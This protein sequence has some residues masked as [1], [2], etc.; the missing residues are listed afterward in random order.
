MSTWIEIEHVD[1][2]P[3]K[4][5]S[6]EDIDLTRLQ[7]HLEMGRALRSRDPMEYL[8]EQRGVTEVEGQLV[9]TLGGLV[10]F[11]RDP[12]RHL[13]HTAI[14]LT[15][16]SGAAPNSQQVLDIRD[17]RGT[18]FDMIDA[19]EA[20]LWAQS[21]HGFR[22][23]NGPRRIPLDQYP[24]PAL[25]E[26]VVNAMAHRDYRVTGSRVK[27]EMF[28]NQVEWSSPGGLPAGVTV[29]NI[30]KAQYTRNPI[31]VG[32]LW[33]AGYIEQRGMGLDSVVNLL[34]S[35]NLAYPQMEDTG[36]SFLIR[37]EGHG[38]VDRHSGA[39]LSEPLAQI[40]VLVESAGAAGVSAKAIAQ[41]LATPIRTVN[42]RLGELVDRGLV[43]RSGATNRTRYLAI[44]AG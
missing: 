26:L 17:L 5:A 34:G 18:L 42:Y 10:C 9:P 14:A 11:G 7:R 16:Y 19:T 8:T 6:L 36:A 23:D 21:N 39:G 12:Q 15:R 29:E 38:S 37:I 35:E 25:R 30:L 32:F 2:L 33:D 40:F 27:I 28:K 20:Y 22:I 13:P 43:V 24:R 3:V 1:A 31:I 41:R 4:G 44:P